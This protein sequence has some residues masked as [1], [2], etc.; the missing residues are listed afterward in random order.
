[1][2]AYAISSAWRVVSGLE[3]V[4]WLEF[5]KFGDGCASRLPTIGDFC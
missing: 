3:A 5:F 2:V 1:M 4:S